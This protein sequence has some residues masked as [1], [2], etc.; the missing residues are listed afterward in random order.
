VKRLWRLPQHLF[1]EE[2]ARREAGEQVM[3]GAG[4]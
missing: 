2:Q 1:G 4:E 3:G